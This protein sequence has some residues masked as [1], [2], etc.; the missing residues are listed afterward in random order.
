LLARQAAAAR[1][2]GRRAARR[3]AVA[4]RPLAHR[5]DQLT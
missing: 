2:A 4:R 5:F 1:Q 3:A